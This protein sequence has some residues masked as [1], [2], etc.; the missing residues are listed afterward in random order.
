MNYSF[1]IFKSPDFY[2]SVTTDNET[3]PKVPKE[4]ENGNNRRSSF[5]NKQENGESIKIIASRHLQKHLYL[6]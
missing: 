3:R 1:F 6:I 2:I 4:K 5:E